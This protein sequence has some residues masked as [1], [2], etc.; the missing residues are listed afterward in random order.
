MNRPLVYAAHPMTTYGT[1]HARRC[2][3]GL[4]GLLSACE[5][6]DPE[7][8]AWETDEARLSEWR[9]IV[10]RLTGLVVFAAEDG[11]IGVGCVREITDAI[12]ESVPVAAYSLVVGLV[13]LAA[14]DFLPQGERSAR[15]VGTMRIGAPVTWSWARSPADTS[16][17]TN[18]P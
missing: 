8:R 11:T 13:D 15:R 12:A 17:K 2:L 7:A 3:S 4:A 5:L 10:A 6:L 1:D 9:I 14:V 16:R 18:S